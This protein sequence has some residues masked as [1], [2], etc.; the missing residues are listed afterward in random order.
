MI[1]HVTSDCFLLAVGHSTTQR[2][3]FSSVL[4][5]FSLIVHKK[6][7]RK[8]SYRKDDRAMHPLWVSWKFSGVP[9]SAQCPGL[10]FRVMLWLCVQNL[11]FV[12]LPAP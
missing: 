3:W 7:T 12:A 10:F 11:K 2:W 1:A 9:D 6:G 8:L 4:F 5:Y